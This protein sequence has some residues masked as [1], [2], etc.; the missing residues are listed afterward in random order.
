MLNIIYY[1]V[2]KGPVWKAVLA[3]E[4]STLN[5]ERLNNNN[6]TKLCC[7]FFPE[8]YW[9]FGCQTENNTAPCLKCSSCNKQFCKEHFFGHSKCTS[10]QPGKY[11]V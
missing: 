7:S 4:A 10:A 1:F 2:N 6:N 3:T 11:F 5:K 8:I 9:C